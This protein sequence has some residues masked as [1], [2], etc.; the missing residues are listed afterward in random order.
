MTLW[1]ASVACSRATRRS[2][3]CET[4]VHFDASPETV[5]QGMLFYEEVPRRPMPLLRVFLPAPV[6][7]Q[8]DKTRVGA[9]IECTYDGGYLEKRIT[10][11]ER[12][13]LRPLRRAR[14]AAG[15]RGLHLDERGL[16]RDAAPHGGRHRGRADDAVSW[17]PAAPL[18]VASVRALPRA[19]A[20]PPH[21]R[22]DARRAGGAF[23]GRGLPARRRVSGRLVSPVPPDNR[24]P[25]SLGL[26]ELRGE[27]T[28]APLRTE[29][30]PRD[31]RS[32]LAQLLPLLGNP[33]A[34]VLLVASAMSA[35]SARW[36]TPRSSGDGVFSVAINL[37]PDVA[38]AEGRREAARSTSRRRPPCC[39]TDAWCELPR[40]EIVPGRP[41]PALGRGP[42]AR[43]RAPAR[44]ARPARAT[45]GADGRVAA[46]REGGRS[47]GGRRTTATVWLGTSVVSGTATARGDGDRERHAV[48]RRHRAARG[49]RRPRPSSSE[50]SAT[51][52]CSSRARSWCSCSCSSPRAW[53]CTGPPFESLLFAVA[54]AVG[55]HAR[56]PADDHDRDA[57][58]RG[59]ADGATSTS[60]SS[61]SP[62]SRTSAA[63]TCSAATR[64]ARLRS[65]EMSARR[66]VRRRT[67][68]RARAR[69]R[70]R[71]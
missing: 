53:P 33:L 61:T 24:P 26:T 28:P 7:T 55:P 70:W 17:P 36:S 39:A 69:S 21:P 19:P 64:P 71:A 65:G 18:A 34:L 40:R 45:G 43:R 42:R 63:S 50:A 30:A 41:R 56:V 37:V 4:K 59:V 57:R 22:R 6:R 46:G 25:A 8:G 20:A 38:V 27:G 48:R 62:P 52:A 10:E 12:G 2:R 16:L 54:L 31:R 47:S 3:P 32:P 35:C 13:A 58:A 68:S 23:R 44:G 51:S 14:P 5:W 66:L 1:P 67:A 29:R 9:I 15:H 11:A 49:P 60:S